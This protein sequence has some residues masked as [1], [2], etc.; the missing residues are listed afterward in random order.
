MNMSCFHK[1]KQKT[2]H[3][4]RFFFSNQLKVD[5]AGWANCQSFKK[6]Q[7][8]L[9]KT[10]SLSRAMYSDWDLSVYRL[11]TRSVYAWT[12]TYLNLQ[13]GCL[14][15]LFPIHSTFL[16]ESIAPLSYFP[17][18]LLTISTYLAFFHLYICHSVLL[19]FCMPVHNLC[20][21]HL[22]LPVYFH[23]RLFVPPELNVLSYHVAEV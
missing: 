19:P 1:T 15:P 17:S 9:S 14:V 12:C 10:A 22:V 13:M 2:K 23:T 8:D 3:F 11:I 7:T 4:F 20:P 21:E 5:M 18:L 16:T 6:H